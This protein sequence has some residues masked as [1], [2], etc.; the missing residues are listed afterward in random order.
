MRSAKQAAATLVGWAGVACSTFAGQSPRVPSAVVDLKADSGAAALTARWM[1]ADADIIPATNHWPGPDSKATGSENT[2]HTLTLTTKDLKAVRAASTPIAPT[3]LEQR[4]T[5]GRVAFGWYTLD[6]TVPQRVGELDMTGTTLVFEVVVDDYAEVWV[7]GRANA[8]LGSSRGP[9][10]SGWNS[11]TR[12]LLTRDAVPGK[13]HT[14]SILAANG[15]MSDPPSNFVWVRSAT[16]DVYA[17][18]RERIGEPVETTIMRLDPALDDIIAPGTKIERLA[19][20][21]VFGEGPV[22]VPAKDDPVYY[23]GGGGGGY[24]L[25][26]D[27]NQNIIHRFDPNGDVDGSVTVYRSKSGYAGSDI[28]TYFQPGSNG[29]ALDAQG[30]L[31]IC[32][33]GNRRVTRLEKNGSLTVIVDRFEDKRL[34]SPNDLVYR[35]DGTLYFTDPP[36]GLPK[37]FGDASKELPFS[38]VYLVTSE[39]TAKLA[40]KDLAA[41]NGLAFTPDEK[42]LYVNNWET[43][44]KVILR[45]NVA[46]DGSLSNPT[47]FFDMTNTPG[48]ICLDGMKVDERGNVFVSGPGG[49]WIISPGGQHLGTI[50]GPELPANFTWGDADGRTLYLTARTGLYRMRTLTPGA[51]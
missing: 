12:V 44:R 14:V 41:P 17:G 25:F 4:R 21:F 23:G 42:H 13:T 15:P 33:H 1:Y 28:G 47:T 31:T 30:R 26:S 18:D 38:G 40:A 11:P 20:G 50:S 45:Y 8:V 37:A 5:P 19:T 3:S 22:W 49:V 43:N 35:S 51:R 32:E 29:L 27:P 2:T 46:A 10:V 9:F 7:D 48:E 24:L 39:G 36:F 6:F 16:L 34:N